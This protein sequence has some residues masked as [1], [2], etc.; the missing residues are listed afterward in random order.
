MQDIPM[1]TLE[2]VAT[3]CHALIDGKTGP[4]AVRAQFCCRLNDAAISGVAWRY[5]NMR[6][7][8]RQAAQEFTGKV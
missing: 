7:T 3:A 6:I 4:A 5:V 2:R 1:V 8:A